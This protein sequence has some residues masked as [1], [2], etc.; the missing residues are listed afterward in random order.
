MSS[1][2]GMIAIDS[3]VANEFAVELEGERLLGIFR[4]SGLSTFK[5]NDSGQL[6]YRPIQINKMVQ[7]DGNNPFNKWLR[8]TQASKNSDE[9][10]TRTLTI[11]AIDDEVEIRRWTLLG[12]YIIEVSYSAFDTASA[13]MVEEIVTIKYNSLEEVWSATSALD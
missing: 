1:E 8:E 13:E 11:V 4:V 5:L 7:R 10:P 2:N 12:A 3:L 9:R 6:V